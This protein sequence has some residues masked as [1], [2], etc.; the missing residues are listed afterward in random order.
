[1]SYSALLYR[2]ADRT[3]GLLSVTAR[4]SWLQGS[5]TGVLR[6]AGDPDPAAL[7]SPNRA[8]RLPPRLLAPAL[9]GYQSGRVGLGVVAALLDEDADT[10]YAR[11]ADDE[12]RPP[13]VQDDLADL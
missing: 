4:D 5:P 6:A 9:K 8:R 1:V 12:I 3:V 13:V 2:L 10:L 11:L 7:T